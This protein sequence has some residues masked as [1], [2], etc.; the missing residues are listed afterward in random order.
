MITVFPSGEYFVKCR[1]SNCG[2]EIFWNQIGKPSKE[3]LLN[4]NFY[5]DEDLCRI[6]HILKINNEWHMSYIKNK[7]NKHKQ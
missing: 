6:C 7:E 4:H 3:D 5:R 1:C 2:G